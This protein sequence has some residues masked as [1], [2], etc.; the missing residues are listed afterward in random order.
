MAQ[1]KITDVAKLA[2]VGISTVSRVLNNSGYAS[3]KTRRK[4]LKAVE[5][6]RYEPNA[7]A[8]GLVQKTT[9]LIGVVISDILNPFYSQ[10]VRSIESTCDIDG[11]S[12]IL[13]NTDESI[14]KEKKYLKILLNKH[15]DGIIMAGGR[16]V[17]EKYNEHLFEAAC[18]VPMILSN[19]F[20]EHEK[21]HCV[22]CDKEKGAYDMTN[23]LIGLGHKNI[24]H[25]AGYSDYKPT[26]D[27]LNGFCRA[28]MEK[29][30]PVSDE[31]VV[32]S[33]YHSA[34]GHAAATVLLKRAQRPTAIFASND[35]MAAGVI[36]ALQENHVSIPGEIAVVGSDNISLGE[37]L[38]PG[39]TTINHNVYE[40]GQYSVSTLLKLIRG[41]VAPKKTVLNTELIIRQS[42]GGRA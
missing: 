4:V 32:Y 39:L 7:I 19:E 37:L 24:A 25:I 31:N 18:D 17:G 35:L 22:Y 26:Q 10:L 11:Y 15:V 29:H 36:K 28:M 5:Y 23:Y 34:G 27:R 40:L 13:C 6:Y 38:T 1:S 21:I 9:C 41:E 8:K 2:G 3:E 14:D 16:G 12:V 20:I 33:D 30:I 42:C